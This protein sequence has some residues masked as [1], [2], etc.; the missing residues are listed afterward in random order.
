MLWSGRFAIA[1]GAEATRQGGGFR[2]GRGCEQALRLAGDMGGDF[3]PC[4]IRLQD[5]RGGDKTGQ[6]QHGQVQQQ[7]ERLFAGFVAQAVLRDFG[8]Q[9]TAQGGKDQQAPLGDAALGVGGA[10]FVHREGGIGKAVGQQ[11]I[12]RKAKGCE[13]GG[14]GGE[15]CCDHAASVA[16]ER[17]GISAASGPNGEDAA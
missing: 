13:G 3:V 7:A 17:G 9:P 15:E 14:A 12:A 8:P 6:H 11:D 5:Q 10:G 16:A 1:A 2:R 4:Q